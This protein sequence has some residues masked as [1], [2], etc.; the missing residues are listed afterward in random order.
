M[1]VDLKKQIATYTAPAGA[2]EVVTVPPLQYLMLD[3]H[4]DPNT[5]QAY[6]DALSTL[7]PVAYKLKFFSKTTLDMDYV[8]MPLEA[9]WW[10]QDMTAF[11][12]ARDKSQWDWTVMNL[13]PHWITDDHVADVI[14]M[15]EQKG[16]APSLDLIRLATLDEGLA[17]QTL[18]VGSYDDEAP[19][20]ARLH[21]EYLPANGLVATGRHHEIYLNDPRHT[22]ADKL[23]TILRQP[24]A[25]S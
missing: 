8:V 19:V 18:H 25:H 11:T 22:E 13:V 3:G 10:A 20:L 6:A 16:D 17:V 21:E 1:K 2:F 23:R 12:A 7:Y 15:L 24:V 9:L 4:G 5:S 14:A